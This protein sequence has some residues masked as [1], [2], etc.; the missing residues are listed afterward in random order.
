MTW[1]TQFRPNQTWNR[2]FYTAGYLTD[3][4]YTLSKS[5]QMDQFFLE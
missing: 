4:G 1:K 3:I 2:H 5:R